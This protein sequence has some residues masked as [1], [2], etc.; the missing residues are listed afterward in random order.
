MLFRIAMR[1][2]F[3]DALA[4]FIGYYDV[5]QVTGAKF[6]TPPPP[7]SAIVQFDYKLAPVSSHLKM[8]NCSVDVKN[9]C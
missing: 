7:N 5:V 1:G 4:F 9:I 2:C 3:E 8:A 6:A